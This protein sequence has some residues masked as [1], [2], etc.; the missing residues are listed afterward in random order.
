VKSVHFLRD[1]ILR[2]SFAYYTL[3]MKKK[4]GIVQTAVDQKKSSRNQANEQFRKVQ[5]QRKKMI[6]KLKTWVE[7][8]EIENSEFEYT[9]YSSYLPEKEPE[10][11]Q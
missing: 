3:V 5:M 9:F 6:A 7:A 1:G 10:L 8:T 4:D 11:G 2:N